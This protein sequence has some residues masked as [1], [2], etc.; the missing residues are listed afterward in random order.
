MEVERGN[1]APKREVTELTLEISKSF[2]RI[3]LDISLQAQ[4][5]RFMVTGGC[6]STTFGIN[7]W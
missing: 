5:T 1:Q 6:Q 4:S 7:C 3:G 2:F